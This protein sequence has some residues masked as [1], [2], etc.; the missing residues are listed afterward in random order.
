[1]KKSI[2]LSLLMMFVF[3]ACAAFT[4]PAKPALLADT[5]PIILPRTRMFMIPGDHNIS[6]VNNSKETLKFSFIDPAGAENE[7]IT[8]AAG[9]KEVMGAFYFSD[10]I[11]V[12]ESLGNIVKVYIATNDL[13]QSV[14]ASQEMV[15]W[16][17]KAA[18]TTFPVLKSLRSNSDTDKIPAVRIN[19]DN[20]SIIALDL[21]WMDLEG[22]EV[23]YGSIEPGKLNGGPTFIT[24]AWRLRDQFG[25]I[26][27]EYI[28]TNTAKQTVTITNEVIIASYQSTMTKK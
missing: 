19:F 26:I 10:V 15:D 28:T 25:N 1:M 2:G 6:L 27:L 11:V 12:R 14:T 13:K 20:K 5:P 24:H 22:K 16:A 18:I 8:L 4:V 9:K 7:L 23:K 17:K 3:F 21:Y